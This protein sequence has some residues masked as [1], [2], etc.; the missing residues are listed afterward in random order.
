MR[1]TH[2]FLFYAC[3][4][5]LSLRG[6]E[7]QSPLETAKA[8]SKEETRAIKF[9]E[10]AEEALRASAEKGGFA[11]WNH[12]TNLTDYNE[13]IKLDAE[14]ESAVVAL[15]YGKEAK[16]FNL[17]LI[18]DA[19]VKRK[20]KIISDIGM[21]SLPASDYA[22]YTAISSKMGS[23]YSKAK[24]KSYKDPKKLLSLEPHL[25]EI[26]ATSRDPE[27]LK[28][29]W[30]EWRKVSGGRMRDSYKK[31]IPFINNAARLNGYADGTEMKV[32]NFESDGFVEEVKSVW[33]GLKPLYEQLHAYVRYKLHK[34]YGS[35]VIDP[36]GPLPAHLLGNMWAQSWSNINDITR[37]YP[38]ST[39]INITNELVKQKWNHTRIF[40]SA[41]KFFESIGLEPMPDN[42]WK[43]SMLVRPDDG[44][45]VVCH[46]SAWDFHNNKDYRIKQC[47]SINQDDFSTV[48]HEMGH[49]EY[50]LQYK[51][52]SFLFQSG[53]N[54]GF[55]E[56]VADILSLAVSTT[57]YYKSLDLL[58]KNVNGKD[59]KTNINVLFNTATQKLAFMPF[60][61]LVDKYRWDLYSGVVN[62]KEDLN[63]HWIKLRSEIQG[64]A[65]PEVRYD[66]EG[67]F[68]AGAKYHVAFGAGY[69]RYFTA[70][71]YQFQFYK[72]MCLE[73]GHY[74]PGDPEKP[75]H[76]CNYYGSKEAGNKLKE[77]LKLG[78]SVHWRKAMKVMTGK[79]EMDTSA[80]REYFLPLEK[81][82]TQENRK[83]NV[84][85]GWKIKEPLCLKK[86]PAPPKPSGSPSFHQSINLNFALILPCFYI[87]KIFI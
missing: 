63:C 52:L 53:A 39:D 47:T 41:E 82:L 49:V 77:M 15:K 65:P 29:Y 37:P 14:K 34:K 4:T 66:E 48:H 68:D 36:E 24:V 70:F 62:T 2:R 57:D 17:D 7:C 85:I 51:N 20:L 30:K 38:E 78:S 59:F 33:N 58:D 69:I 83:N 23:T 22:T 3:L 45:N 8:P 10:E 76:R 31:Q 19:F 43:D 86:K 28:Y 35:K 42:F 61:Y 21:A 60:G 75:L 11:S 25:Q 44:R 87:V 26:F 9:I 5:F 46:A 84:T 27:E 32:A 74:V 40:R 12:A 80:F 71:I 54:Y 56:G 50:Y 1:E 79:E 81:W 72:A 55:H 73:S 64:I 67:Y 13:K 16:G 18:A 6:L